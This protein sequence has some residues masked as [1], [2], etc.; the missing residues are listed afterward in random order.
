MVLYDYRVGDFSLPPVAQNDI[1]PTNNEEKLAPKILDSS[2]YRSLV[3]VH[4]TTTAIA[5]GRY[6]DPYAGR[7]NTYAANDDVVRGGAE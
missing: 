7:S 2:G 3:C 6:R 5:P 1:V 4:V